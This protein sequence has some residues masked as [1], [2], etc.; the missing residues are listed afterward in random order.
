VHAAGGLR[1]LTRERVLV[2]RTDEL[3]SE[4]TAQR[5]QAFLGV[6]VPT[7]PRLYRT[8]KVVR[9]VKFPFD[10][11]PRGYADRALAD[12]LRCN[13]QC[14]AIVEALFPE[15]WVMRWVRWREHTISRRASSSAHQKQ[16]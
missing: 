12:A 10:A 9:A 8:P 16:K 4:R 14:A 1:G 2:L 6:D 7:M 13:P 15:P 3:S 11:L 5:L